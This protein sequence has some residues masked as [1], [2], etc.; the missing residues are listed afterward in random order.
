[1]KTFIFGGSCSGKSTF[2][3]EMLCQQEANKIYLATMIA[4]DSESVARIFRHQEQRKNKGFRTVEMG[5]NLSQFSQ[6]AEV[7]LLECLG[8]LVA[9]EMFSRQSTPVSSEEVVKIILNDLN[10]LEQKCKH[11]V[12]VSN[13]V[14]QDGRIDVWEDF[15]GEY[16]KALGKLHLFLG[17]WCENVIELVYGIPIHHKGGENEVFF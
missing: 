5:Y 16:L 17:K 11:L 7:I 2:A 1:M 12:I 3:E 13:D 9:N 15:T 6:N 14:F 8:N 4:K 10:F